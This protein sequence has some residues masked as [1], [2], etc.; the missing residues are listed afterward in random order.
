MKTIYQPFVILLIL[1]SLFSCKDNSANFE[2]SSIES[3]DKYITNEELK[4]PNIIKNTEKRILFYHEDKRKTDISLV[5]IHGYSASRQELS[6]VVE[7]VA[8]NLNANVFFTRLS[9]HGLSSEDMVNATVENLLE[10]AAEAI[11]IGNII[12]N[13]VVV[14]GNSV[15]AALSLLMHDSYIDIIDSYVLIS[16]C[17]S[18]QDKRSD[19]LTLPLGLGT[20]I[21]KISVGEI[22]KFTP[23]NEL[24]AKYWTEE[25]PSSA[26]VDM[27][28]IVKKARGMDFDNFNIPIQVIYNPNDDVIDTEFVVEFYDR[29]NVQNKEIHKLYS[30]NGHD[31]TGNINYPENTQATIA[32]IENF[33]KVNIYK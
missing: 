28:K 30:S 31:I 6:P 10:D 29:L 16:P 24:H 23:K 8:H 11:E 3:C 4:N 2:F 1:V 27:M 33:I 15:G 14:I 9:G 7:N 26:I 32:L 5:Y 13:K 22:Y 19:L 12:G 25:Y 20:L 18:L 17:L 21:A